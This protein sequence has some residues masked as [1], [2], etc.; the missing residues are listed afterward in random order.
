[1]T[2]DDREREEIEAV[3]AD[4]LSNDV[5]GFTG[6]FHTTRR[7]LARQLLAELDERGFKVV[8]K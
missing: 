6:T 1:M 8:R 3:V 2:A 4:A 5:F 7:W